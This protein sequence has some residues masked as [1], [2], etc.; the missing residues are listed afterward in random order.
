MKKDYKKGEWYINEKLKRMI[1][2]DNFKRKNWKEYKRM[3]K[4]DLLKSMKGLVG[5]HCYLQKL[6][7]KITLE[8]NFLKRKIGLLENRIRLL[9][10]HGKRTFV[11]D[12]QYKRK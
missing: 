11:S 5:G 2:G 7:M 12:K 1:S 9:T 10:K 6:Y 4:N 3:N 8:N